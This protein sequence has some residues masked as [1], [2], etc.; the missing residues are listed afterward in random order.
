[1][2]E[3]DRINHKGSKS[4]GA[5]TLGNVTNPQQSRSPSPS[6]SDIDD[7]GSGDG[8]SSEHSR[9]R[10]GFNAQIAKSIKSK[11]SVTPKVKGREINKDRQDILLQFEKDVAPLGAMA[12]W[13]LGLWDKMNHFVK[14]IA[15][16]ILCKHV[17][18]CG[19]FEILENV[20][21][22]GNDKVFLKKL[23]YE[24]LGW[25]LTF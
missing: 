3:L 14:R 19:M 16:C 24:E 5:I 7:I 6:P 23:K 4:K 9:Q 21:I 1:M 12:C 22:L 18:R 20:D 13:N 11:K 8:D 2:S 15:V 17:S 10:S 25:L